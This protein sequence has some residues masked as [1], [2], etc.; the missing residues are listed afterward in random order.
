MRESVLE[1]C[2]LGSGMLLFHPVQSVL[3]D[4]SLHL[5]L[6]LER[7]RFRGPDRSIRGKW[8]HEQGS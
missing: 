6:T 2:V 1:N 8:G 3:D 7:R 4:I 5:V